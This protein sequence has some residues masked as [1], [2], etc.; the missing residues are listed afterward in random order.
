MPRIAKGLRLRLREREGRP[1]VYVICDGD[2]EVSTGC[3][4]GDVRGANQRLARYAAETF[5]PDRKQRDLAQI[6]V[7]DV[8]V[9]YLRDIA[10]TKPSAK[11]LGYHGKAL[12]P[13]W[14]DKTL[15]DVRGSTCRKYL[16]HRA[17]PS[18][19]ISSIEAK[20]R[21]PP[22][23]KSSTVRRELKTLQA[24]IN[25]WHK[26][27]PL[28]AVPKVSLPPEGERRERVLSRSEVAKLLWACRKRKAP[29]V[30]RFILIGLYT[31]TRHAALLSLKWL[32]SLSS[33]HIDL[34]KSIVFRRGGAERETSKRRTPC[35]LEGRVLGHV[36]RW[37]IRD[38]AL[39]RQAV[40]SHN[41][42][43][44]T[45]MKRAWKGVVKAAGLGPDV[46]PHVLR[47]TCISWLL[48]KGWPIADVAE[49]VG[50][51][52]T[53]IQKTYWHHRLQAD[54][55]R[56]KAGLRRAG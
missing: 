32:P 33:G 38:R 51:D 2:K 49:H 40:I 21:K 16:E 25:Y 7:R 10:P 8:I 43:S 37:A 26:E 52:I 44:I 54:E 36:R 42:D 11:T 18:S 30:A 24:A 48:W 5:R 9:L 35:R 47:H 23:I 6:S 22:S 55:S 3:G 31:G 39:G 15:D 56:A 28:E 27:S 53:T 19:L 12:L 34:E 41:G 50:A 45:K 1:A 20:K 4:P 46:T 29:H 14:G 17:S 13:F